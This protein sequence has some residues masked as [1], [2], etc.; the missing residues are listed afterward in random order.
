[1]K[2][3]VQATIWLES[4]LYGSGKMAVEKTDSGVNTQDEPSADVEAEP[5]V[6]SVVAEFGGP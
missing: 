4:A 3:K 1:M 6:V 2:E 5:K